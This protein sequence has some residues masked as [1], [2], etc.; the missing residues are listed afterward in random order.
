M[1]LVGV[2]LLLLLWSSV[3]SIDISTFPR[4]TSGPSLLIQITPISTSDPVDAKAVDPCGV[5]PYHYLF[6]SAWDR[7]RVLVNWDFESWLSPK[8]EYA[9]S[10]VNEDDSLRGQLRPDLLI[11]YSFHTLLGAA[12][13]AILL[14]QQFPL[15]QQF[16]RSVPTIDLSCV[17]TYQHVALIL[18]L[19]CAQVLTTFTPDLR[20][21]LLPLYINNMIISLIYIP[22]L[23]LLTQGWA[24]AYLVSLDLS[25]PGRWVCISQRTSVNWLQVWIITCAILHSESEMTLVTISL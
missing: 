2:L 4:I 15:W 9:K 14:H 7:A 17:T 13:C 8:D 12:S 11:Y 18:S 23:T 1:A 16:I 5:S 21:R 25:F 6:F 3:R 20:R 22:I 10:K 19:K 24:V